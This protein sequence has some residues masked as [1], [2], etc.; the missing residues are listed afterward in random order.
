[1]QKI[2]EEKIYDNDWPIVAICYDF[3]KT[4]SPKDMQE[5]GLIPKL[6]C[7]AKSF[8]KESNK[9]AKD[10]GMD[11]ILAYMKVIIDKANGLGDK[12]RIKRED[13]N[14]L[15]KTIKLFNGVESW[16]YRI[17]AIAKELEI[18]VE[19]YIIS[20]GL[21]EIIE[22]TS[23][24]DCFTQ[25]YASEFYYNQYG[26]PCWPC[27]VVNYKSKTQYLFRISKNCLDLSDEDKINDYIPHN[28][29]RI[30]LRRFIYIGD[31][32]T[33][34]PAM[35]IV[36]QGGGTSIGV[37][38]P[39]KCNLDRVTRLLKQERIDFLMPADYSEGS[40][41]ENIVKSVL[42]KVKADSYLSGYN[43]RQEAFVDKLDEVSDFVD[44][45]EDFL[46]SDDSDENGLKSLKKQGKKILRRMKKETEREFAEIGGKKEIEV[47]MKQ[48]VEKMLEL[49]DK[50]EKKL[51]KNL[52]KKQ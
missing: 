45:T 38:N 11:K 27:Q 36:K 22:G 28:A 19:H 29:R 48:R 3:D 26:A 20:A 47:Y 21:K 12:V 6:K 24:A 14:E 16:F 31:S 44:Y 5:F 41:I 39:E 49:F 23:I 30:P 42:K 4:L 7:N 17:N 25:V 18:N 33:D 1:M 10:N 40:K 9:M 46:Y 37:Y 8:W 32:E 13:F 50:K 52:V 35:K 15:G 2:I 51:K 34:I 43:S